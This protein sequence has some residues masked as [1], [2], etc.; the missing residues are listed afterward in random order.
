MQQN[1]AEAVKWSRSAAEQG[2]AGAQCNLGKMYA[3]GQSVEQ[4][5]AKV[6]KTSTKPS[7]PLSSFVFLKLGLQAQVRR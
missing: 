2:Y 6:A 5:Y 7:L 1:Y 3:N 4:D